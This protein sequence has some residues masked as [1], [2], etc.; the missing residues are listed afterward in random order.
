MMCLN[1]LATLETL[2]GERK[3]KFILVINPLLPPPL[4]KNRNITLWGLI[5]DFVIS[6]PHVTA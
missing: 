3:Q 1:Y 2:S 5:G 6:R 4:A